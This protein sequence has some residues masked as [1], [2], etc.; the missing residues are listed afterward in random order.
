MKTML[1]YLGL[2]TVSERLERLLAA[3]ASL[4]IDANHLAS[5]AWAHHLRKMPLIRADE[6]A[7]TLQ[8][9]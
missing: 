9:F 6:E 4:L 7:S 8:L 2:A 3:G 5:A 1:Q